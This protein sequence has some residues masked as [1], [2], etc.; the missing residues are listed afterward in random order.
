M[1][2]RDG[3][4]FL[5]PGRRPSVA[6]EIRPPYRSFRRPGPAPM[7]ST[8]GVT[9]ADVQHALAE[10]GFYYGP[11][12]GLIGPMSRRAIAAFQAEAGLAP[13]GEINASLLRALG[14]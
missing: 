14:L 11:I 12:D 8:V 4:R 2:H 3:P 7:P 1:T 9:G 13:T 6:L 5:E 10:R